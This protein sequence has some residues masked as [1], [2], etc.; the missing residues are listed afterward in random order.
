MSLPFTVIGGFLG[1]GK[2]T[3]L[4]HWLRHNAGSRLAVLVNDFGA[5][6]IDAGLI[7]SAQGDTIA[8]TN[9]CVCCQ[10][11]DDLSRALMQVLETADAFDAVI[12]E[13]SGVSDPWRIAQMGRADPGLRL[14]G[15]IVVV[16][17]QAALEQARDPLLADTLERQL[18]AA[19]LIVVNKCDDAATV[20]RQALRD[21]I[22]SVAG[23]VPRFET[24]RG[25]VPLELLGGVA[26]GAHAHRHAAA[27]HDVDHAD[28]GHDHGH[29]DHGRLF[30]TWS[31]RPC[32]TFEPAALRAWLAAPPPGLLRLKGLL[33]TGI[34]G[35]SELQ[36]AGR[37]GT[38]RAAREP[39]GGAAVVAI[40]LRGQLPT[41]QL[42]AAFDDPASTGPGTPHAPR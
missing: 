14:D 37:H 28:H 26:W 16:D 12:V 34:S 40:A 3:L 29:A 20:E 13:A 15:V 32:R 42:A 21:W 8:L 23:A 7:E 6:N 19:D 30:D 22:A 9:G 4:N 38:L 33:R 31:C 27:D 39:A 36:F 25:V 35:W 11:G 24:M 41:A 2:T 17:A 10:I 18:R 1:A 5:I